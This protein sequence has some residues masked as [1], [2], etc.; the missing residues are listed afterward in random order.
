MWVY[1]EIEPEGSGL[2]AKLA[3]G[4]KKAGRYPVLYDKTCRALSMKFPEAE[5][6]VIPEHMSGGYNYDVRLLMLQLRL[7]TTSGLQKIP[8]KIRFDDEDRFLNFC[9]RLEVT[10]KL[11][12]KIGI[13]LI[14]PDGR[15]ES[16]PTH[17]PEPAAV[18]DYLKQFASRP[19]FTQGRHNQANRWGP[20]VFFRVLEQLDST[21][22]TT[23]EYIEQR[24]FEEPYLK[25]LAGDMRDEGIPSQL[26]VTLRSERDKFRNM[27]LGQNHD[28][29]ILVAEDRLDE[30]WREVYQA[31]LDTESSRISVDWAT[32]V[33]EAKA[34]FNR[35]VDLVV[36]DVRLDPNDEEAAVPTG[37][38]LA[39]WLRKQWS[40]IPILAATASNKTWILE[41]LLKEGIQGYWVKESPEHFG[42]LAHAVHNVID[43]YRKARKI[44]E[45][46]DRTRPWIEGLYAI[47]DEV[48]K[49]DVV[50]EKILRNKAQSLHALLHR[51]FTPFSRELD[52]GL[53]LNVAFLIMFSC[54]NDLRAWCCRVEEKDDSG[55]DWIMAEELGGEVLVTKR[56]HGSRKGQPKFVYQVEGSDKQSEA[57]P[58]T[59]ASIALLTKL[60][61]A[62]KGTVFRKLKNEVRNAIPLTHGVSDGETA[63]RGG[64]ATATTNDITNMLDVLQTLVNK[65]REAVHGSP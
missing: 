61:C 22:A 42:N 63:Q 26:L 51:A 62:N 53:Q 18:K 32:T 41:P 28:R 33:D 37:I 35:D 14:P 8:I 5:G 4:E 56:R 19:W 11:L 24:M 25:H 34:K 44:L 49:T 23:R 27:L 21:Y 30:G 43:L 46:S 15:T 65:R 7:E 2:G 9:D 57:F 58:D 13:V 16:V 40:P 1:L 10:D 6:L 3:T 59:E 29:K 64:V 48:R 54:M 36:L 31:L 17:R 20:Y 12:E 39:K 38:T 50:Q 60:G 55:K 45:W 47:A 52:E